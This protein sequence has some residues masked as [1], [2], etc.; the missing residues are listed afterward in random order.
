MW[1][2]SIPIRRL[3]MERTDDA[4]L[5]YNFRD[6]HRPPG[7][8]PTFC[9]KAR[10]RLLPGTGHQ[11]VG[12]PFTKSP[13]QGQRAPA[14]HDA[15]RRK[16]PEPFG[17]L[18]GSDLGRILNDFGP[19]CQLQNVASF[20]I[21][22]YQARS[23][24]FKEIAERIEVEIARIIRNRQHAVIGDADKSCLAAAM[25]DVRLPA[26]CKINIGRNEKCV[27][28]DDRIPRPLIQR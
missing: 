17:P 16:I 14:P 10:R 21:R 3:Q 25:G 19:P 20:E 22:E 9:C 27:G 2:N 23:R 26:V 18:K 1:N 8:A 7:G 4:A 11:R 5:I 24:V 28:F 13:A 6:S 12:R 15:G